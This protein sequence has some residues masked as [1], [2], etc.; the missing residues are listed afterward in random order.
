M[1][2]LAIAIGCFG[3]GALFLASSLYIYGSRW[4]VRRMRQSTWYQAYMLNQGGSWFALRPWGV[5]LMTFA[6][7][8]LLPDGNP[9]RL[10]VFWLS[11]TVALVGFVFIFWLPDW[12]RP[13]WARP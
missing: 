3:I 5:G 12:A 7:F 8:L 13:P 10:L 1:A 4:I 9:I 11:V 6:L 2:R